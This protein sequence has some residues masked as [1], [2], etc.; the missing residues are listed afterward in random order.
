MGRHETVGAHVVASA[1][2]ARAEETA[3]QVLARLAAE[4]S[5]A[6]ELVLVLDAEGRL[7]G[8]VPIGKLFAAGERSTLGQIAERGFP[9]VTPQTDQEHAA[10]LALHHRVDALPVVDLE[11]RPLGVMPSQALLQVLRR[12]HVEDLHLLAGIRREASQARHAIE[13]PPLRRARHRLPWLAAGLGGGA[14]AT[15]AMAAFEST[16]RAQ[17]AVAFFIPAIVYLA[18][19]IGTQSEAIAVR[20]LS[21]TRAGIG[22]LLAG[23]LRTGMLLGAI[24]GLMSFLPVWFFFGARLAGAVSSAIFAAGA[25]AAALGLLLPWWLARA[26]RDP[27]L[28]SGPIATVIQDV[29]SLLVYFGVVRVFGL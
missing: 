16:L 12:E 29:V 15:A 1:P 6:V 25:V 5:A 7:E 8:A 3:A 14:L 17:I 24:L 19:A 23:E 9:R 20:G 2:R 22:H 4:R 18:D 10:S 13:D 11:G 28:G 26:G 27:A 21:L